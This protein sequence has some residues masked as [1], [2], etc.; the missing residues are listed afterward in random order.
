[1]KLTGANVLSILS[2]K[3]LRCKTTP[4]IENLHK[5]GNR[6]ENKPFEEKC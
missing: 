6:I 4:E 5:V 2:L 1:M 3:K